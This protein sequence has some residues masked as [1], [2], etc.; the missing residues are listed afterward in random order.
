MRPPAQRQFSGV[1]QQIRPRFGTQPVC[2]PAPIQNYF[3]PENRQNLMTQA[4]QRVYGSNVMPLMTV[5]RFRN[6]DPSGDY[7]RHAPVPT[8]DKRNNPVSRPLMTTFE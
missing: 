2:Q 6:M 8:F 7:S 5:N 3:Q 1:A 4:C